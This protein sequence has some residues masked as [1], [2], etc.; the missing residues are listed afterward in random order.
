LQAAAE[1]PRA[2]LR[3][4]RTLH[5]A[6]G[7]AVEVR[8]T[9]ENRSAPGR[10]IAWTQHVTLGPPFLQHG[11]T[12]IEFPAE[13]SRTFESDFG[14]VNPQSA[15]DFTWPTAPGLHGGA[16]DLS[17]FS[18]A[19]RSS[20][21]TAHLMSRNFADAYF[22]VYSTTSKVQLQYRWQRADFPW[23]GLWEENR[24]RVNAPWH[25]GVAALGLECGVSP[26]PETRRTIID[27]RELFGVPTYRGMAAQASV[28]V[29]Y[30]ISMRRLS[31]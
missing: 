6:G 26:F 7:D 28:T 24:Q 18:H 2:G 12:R 20:K 14:E 19:A 22:S 30:Q 13:R 16:V 4:C 23:L 21:D 10:P 29:Q 11:M 15:E 1:L 25:G 27:R 9:V 3:I 31:H 5:L 17:V 8:E